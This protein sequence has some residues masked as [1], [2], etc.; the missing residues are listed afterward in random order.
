MDIKDKVVIVTGAS[1]GIGLVLSK[2]LTQNGAKVALIARSKDILD[3]LSKE[4]KDSFPLVCDMSKEN[5]VIDMIKKVKNH[6]GKIDILINNAGRGYFSPIEKIDTKILY[7]L[8]DLNLAGPI[9]AM[10]EVIPIM[11]DQ[12]EGRIINISSGTALMYIPN[13]SVYS[14][15]KRALGAISFTANEELKDYNIKVSVV[16]PTLTDTNFSKN[17]A[18]NPEVQYRS[19]NTMTPDT[20]EYIA[21]K[22]IK[23]IKNN[24]IEVFAHDEMEKNR[25]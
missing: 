16:Y 1:S 20:S 17:S 10:R 12:R 6:Y 22:I 2:M 19:S 24:D 3:Q 21:E 25:K 4:L 13:M 5:D 9:I 15:L 11:K 18:R 23:S 14:S 7:E 8:F